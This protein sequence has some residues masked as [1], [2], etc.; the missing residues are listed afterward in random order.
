MNQFPSSTPHIH[1]HLHPVEE[2]PQARLPSLVLFV[3]LFGRNTDGN[4][5]MNYLATFVYFRE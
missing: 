2:H 5:Y 4:P 1:I 3:S